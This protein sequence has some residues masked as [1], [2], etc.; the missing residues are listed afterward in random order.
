MVFLALTSACALLSK[1]EPLQ[2]RYFTIDPAQSAAAPTAHSDLRLRL[3]P[4]MSGSDIRQYLTYRSADHELNYST[5]LRWTERPESYL[6]RSLQRALFEE[7]GIQ[8][9]MSGLAPTLEV[10]LIAFEEVR[11]PNDRVRVAA[12][13]TLHDGYTVKWE[14]T[15][16]REQP[17]GAVRD[18]ERPGEVARQLGAALAALVEDIAAEVVSR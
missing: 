13:V 5:E 9:V 14:K 12:I 6:R 8:R 18:S 7:R 4:V 11:Q 1:N 15:L 2:P 16:N 17:L 10:E 3:G